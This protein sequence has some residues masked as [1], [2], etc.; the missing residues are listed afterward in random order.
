[1][2]FLRLHQLPLLLALLLRFLAFLCL[3]LIR[4]NTG[5]G[6][7]KEKRHGTK[8]ENQFKF[9]FTLLTAHNKSYFCA[10]PCRFGSHFEMLHIIL[11]LPLYNIK[12]N[13]YH[14]NGFKIDAYTDCSRK[15]FSPCRSASLGALVCV[16]VR[17]LLGKRKSRLVFFICVLFLIF[18][19]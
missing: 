18:W 7:E 6:R 12:L 11:W 16:C 10:N 13:G 4:P 8:T 9:I 19:F 5:C 15:E 2:L 14:F 1:M 3:T 17:F